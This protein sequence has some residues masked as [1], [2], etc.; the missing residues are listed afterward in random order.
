MDAEDERRL[1]AL[2]FTVHVRDK[3]HDGHTTISVPFWFDRKQVNGRRTWGAFPFVFGGRRIA[4]FTRFSVA[5]PGYL[6]VF[7]LRRNTRFTGYVPLL[8]RYQKCGFRAEDDARCRYTLW[9]SAP[10]FVYGR[11]GYGRRTHGALVYYWDRRP[12]GAYKL[13]TPLFG[14]N[15]DPGKTL[16][17]YAGPVAVR[18]T[19]TWRR[20]LAF[21]LY[22]R[23]AHRLEKRSLTLA[24]PPLFVARTK[25]DQRF[26]EAGLLVWQFRQPHKVATAVVPPLFFHSHA[27]AERRLTW[28]MPLFVRDDHWAKDATFTGIGPV[29]Y[30]QR[31]SGKNLDFVQFP[32]VWH[33][34]RDDSQGTFG[35]FLW[36]D[37][38]TRKGK[39][40]Q[41]VPGAYMRLANRRRDLKIIGPGL[42]WWRR[43]RGPE[44]G[45]LHWRALFGLFGGGQE[46]GQRYL[47]IFGARIPRGA[48]VRST[49]AGAGAT[50]GAKD[51]KKARAL[52]RA[53]RRAARAQRRAARAQQRAMAA[54]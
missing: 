19:N 27:Y 17:W 30:F 42:G 26:F 12:E 7:R 24:V 37:I 44:E 18:T 51:G 6:D 2:P 13:Y 20:V 5:P 11:D 39:T 3:A 14:V 46:D 47:S 45:D 43:G 41:L 22:F 48:A 40:F 28:L 53:E 29:L 10:L 49:P 50:Q 33:I 9:G 35:A 4:S 8:F 25:K 1:V 32:L 54:R 36:W 34:E 31:R 21:P 15:N 16:G 38:R 23:R 52:A